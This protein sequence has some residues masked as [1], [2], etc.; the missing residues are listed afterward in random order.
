MMIFTSLGAMYISANADTSSSRTGAN[1]DTG[2]NPTIQQTRYVRYR[3]RLYRVNV[4]RVSRSR[5]YRSYRPRTVYYR[6]YNRRSYRRY[7][8][9][10]VRYIRIPR[11]RYYRTYN[12]K[13]YRPR[14]RN[15][16][17]YRY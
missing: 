8:R 15:Y 1:T 11:I 17:Y 9:P 14:V 3:G 2:V 13:Y 7:Y 6:P 4:Q 12:R 5:R 10:R 16:R